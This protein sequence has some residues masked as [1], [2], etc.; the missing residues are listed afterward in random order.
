[1][2]VYFEPQYMYGRNILTKVMVLVTVMDDFYDAFGTFEELAILT[3]A[4][5]R[6]ETNKIIV[7]TFDNLLNILMLH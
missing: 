1:M 6:S 7:L 2:G 4:I 5:E 3:E